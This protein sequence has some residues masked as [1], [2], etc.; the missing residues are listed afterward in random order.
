MSTIATFHAVLKGLPRAVFNRCVERHHADKGCK[1]FRHWDHLL[2]M[3]YA[4]LSGA[5]SLRTLELGFN[6]HSLHHRRLRTSAIHRSTLADASERRSALVFNDTAAWLMGKV[7][8]K[9]RQEMKPLICLLDSTSI[10][11]KGREFDGWTLGNRNRNTQGIKLHVL[12]DAASGAPLWHDF[13]APNV[14]DVTQAWQAP[15][16]HDTLY[17][18]D[19]AYCDYNWWAR[20]DEAGSR[21]VTRF[22][23]NAGIE[24]IEDLPVP[25]DAQGVVLCDEVVRLKYTHSS[26]GRLNHYDKTLR[27]V[28]I[29]RPDKDTPLL[30]AT[31]D[32]HSSALEIGQRYKE[33][34]QIELFFKWLK[35]HLKIKTFLGRSSNAVHIQIV[36]ALIAYLLVALYKQA[37]RLNYTL[38]HCLALIAATLFEP[39]IIDTSPPRTRPRRTRALVTTQQGVPQ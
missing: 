21:F 25:G 16:Q 35:Q 5:S 2:A 4:Q 11:L 30:L 17:V 9:L 10:T 23:S 34:W 8:R 1:R 12:L 18:F 19:K 36:T 28:T 24:S 20:I 6:S 26:K 3:V 15:L 37:H 29:Y 39:P 38:W 14:N 13:S 27:R 31:N 32:F 33:R 22:K 7:S